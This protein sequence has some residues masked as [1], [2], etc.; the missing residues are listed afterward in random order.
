MLTIKIKE[1]DCTV[2]YIINE[3]SFDYDIVMVF[4]T[5]IKLN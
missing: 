4:I 5:G 3:N 2:Y 1:N